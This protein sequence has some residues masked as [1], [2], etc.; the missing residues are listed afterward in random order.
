MSDASP[1][2]FGSLAPAIVGHAAAADPVAVELMQLAAG[3]IDALACRLAS[4]GA[5]R[6]AVVGGLAGS[7][8]PWLAEETRVHLAPP[9][10]DALDGALRLAGIAAGV[11]ADHDL[12]AAAE[13]D[14]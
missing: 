2:E 8:A 4:F 1:R 6:L 10:G 3:H 7:V 9:V 12:T 11:P 13:H 5:Q 14:G